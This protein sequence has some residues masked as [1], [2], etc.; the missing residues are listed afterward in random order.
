MGA[1]AIPAFSAFSEA[2]VNVMGASH[3]FGRIFDAPLLRNAHRGA[4]KD[5][6]SPFVNGSFF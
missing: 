5:T 3:K 6:I 1:D 2:L 4:T